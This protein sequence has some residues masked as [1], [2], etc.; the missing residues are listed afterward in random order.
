MSLNSKL[1]RGICRSDKGIV[2]YVQSFPKPLELGCQLIAMGL[3]VDAGF[4]RSLLHFLSM[5]IEP[6]EKEDVP[7]SQ[8]PVAS[9]DVGGDRGIGVSDMRHRVHIIDGRCDVKGLLATHA[10]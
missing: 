9:E 4:G 8:A 7:A 2:G 1:V 10:V 3:R 6:G 5:F